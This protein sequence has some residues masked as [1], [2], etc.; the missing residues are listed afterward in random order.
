MRPT[1]TPSTPTIVVRAASRRSLLDRPV[2]EGL[3]TPPPGHSGTTLTATTSRGRACHARA[4]ASANALRVEGDSEL[5]PGFRIGTGG[6]PGLLGRV[7]CVRGVC[8]Y[9]PNLDVHGVDSFTYTVID[10]FGGAATATVR[11]KIA[12]VEDAPRIV[13]PFS[14]QAAEGDP[15]LVAVTAIDPDGPAFTLQW[16]ATAP[17]APAPCTAFPFG[18]TATQG[19]VQVSATWP[20]TRSRTSVRR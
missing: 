4:A 2:R 19:A 6:Q 16:M 11:V 10:T 15:V 1:E 18:V 3:P 13:G 12:S 20:P 7:S 9:T 8:A 5:P 17:G 14:V